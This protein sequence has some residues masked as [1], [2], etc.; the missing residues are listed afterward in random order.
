MTHH[1]EYTP[2]PATADSHAAVLANPEPRQRYQHLTPGAVKAT[3]NF[4]VP[5]A[6]QRF[7]ALRLSPAKFSID[8]GHEVERTESCD[9][10]P[11]LVAAELLRKHCARPNAE[12]PPARCEQSEST[13]IT[14]LYI[15]CISS[16]Q[17]VTYDNATLVT[18]PVPDS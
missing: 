2:S 12:T 4:S 5:R 6:K 7:E 15:Y 13:D 16:S 14:K 10:T 9:V 17:P 1:S 8:L 3:V 11:R 18:Y